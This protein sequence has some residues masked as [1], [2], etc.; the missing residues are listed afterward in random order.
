[1]PFL[2][3]SF[4]LPFLSYKSW[5]VSVFFVFLV[6]LYRVVVRGPV[7]SLLS[8][9]RTPNS[10][11]KRGVH[12]VLYLTLSRLVQTHTPEGDFWTTR[13]IGFRKRRIF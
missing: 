7:S 6:V 1:M 13:L 12:C 5:S 10:K 3:T 2:Y 4:V 8:L 9:S 11:I